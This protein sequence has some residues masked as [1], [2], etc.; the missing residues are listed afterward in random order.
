MEEL[1]RLE[2]VVLQY[3]TR[4]LPHRLFLWSNELSSVQA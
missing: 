2:A 4:C 3:G 1:R